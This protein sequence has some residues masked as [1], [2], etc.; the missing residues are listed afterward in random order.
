[1]LLVGGYSLL[2]LA[3]F[4]YV[5]DVLGY[6]KWSFFFRVIGMNSIFIYMSKK[7]IDYS[8]TTKSLF[9]W[10][11]DLV[12]DPYNVVVLA[13]CFVFVKWLVLYFLYRKKVFLS[14]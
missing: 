6:I 9:Q 8:Y 14:V 11:S 3:S 1:V 12:G 4:Y 7:F 2:L 5:I 13:A 10:L